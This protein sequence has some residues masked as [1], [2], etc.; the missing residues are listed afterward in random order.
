[1]KLTEILSPECVCVP[2][3]ASTKREAIERLIGLLASSG[4]LTNSA[5]VLQAVLDRE[6]IRSTGIGYGLAVPHG[7]STA[8][9][10]LMMA[11]GKPAAPIDFGANDGEPASV[12]V[13]LTSPVDQTGPHIQ[14]L[15]RIS[16][17][18]LLES[19]RQAVAETSSAAELYQVIARHET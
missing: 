5:A 15:A 16:R 18:M 10:S 2:L 4:K 6:Q 11:V 17:L 19:F 9:P 1:M 3:E 13:L 14:A 8:V 7:K 12:I